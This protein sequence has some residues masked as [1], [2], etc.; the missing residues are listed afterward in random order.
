MNESGPKTQTQSPITTGAA[1]FAMKFEGGV[2]IAADTLGSY[3]SLAKITNLERVI[4]VND[5]TVMGCSGDVADFQFLQ[6]V[7]HQKQIDENC[8]DDGFSLKPKALHCWLT[9]VMYNRRSKF[10]PLWNEILVGGMQDDEP[11]LGFVNLQGTAFEETVI[12]NGLGG[13][14]AKPV[15]WLAIEKKGGLLNREE[16]VE[17]IQKCV[18]LAYTRDCRAWPKYTL[19][20]IDKTGVKIEGPFTIDSH[21]GYAKGINISY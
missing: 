15:L 5:C 14:M 4:K 16:A 7:I 2:I 10:D 9:R 8:R 13:D 3:G 18:R 20:I 17:A 11:F 6:Q 21:W 1:V 19:A 12:A